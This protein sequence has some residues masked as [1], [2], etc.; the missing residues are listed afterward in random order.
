M[1]RLR[2][3]DARIAETGIGRTLDAKTAANVPYFDE[4]GQYALFHKQGGKIRKFQHGSGSNLFG[5]YSTY[6][7]FKFEFDVEP[8]EFKP[9]LGELGDI[10]NIYEKPKGLLPPSEQQATID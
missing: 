10:S 2:G 3:V 7:P 4:V 8:F 6:E 1:R 5:N 9:K